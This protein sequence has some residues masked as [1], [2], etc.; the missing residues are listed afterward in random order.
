MRSESKVMAIE[1]A[2]HRQS[3]FGLD[4]SLRRCEGFRLDGPAGR[5]GR[6]CGVRFGASAEPEVFEV[7]A[8]LLGRLT[9]LIAASDVQEVIP[10]QRLLLPHGP[11]TLLD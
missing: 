7:Q 5:I 2:E 10:E 9:L 3:S 1:R 4:Y 8:G 6:V 11:P